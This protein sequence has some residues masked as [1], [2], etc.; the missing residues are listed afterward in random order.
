LA[1]PAPIAILS[2]NRPDYLRQVLASLAAQQGAALE[3]RRIILFQDGWHNAYS[4]RGAA[5]FED[6]E[7]CIAA[8]RDLIPGGEVMAASN[9]LGVAENYLRAE[10]HL[11]ETLGA[12]C[13]Y[14]FED[15]LVL[16]PRYLATLD[17][18]RA[19][20]EGMEEVGYFACYGNL[21]ASLADQLARPRQI[22]RL[23]HLW[24]FGLFRRHWQ[25]MQPLLADYYDLVLGRDYHPRARRTPE[26]LARYRAKGIPVAVSSQ[27]DVKKAITYHLGRVALN[28]NLVSARYIGETGLH[29]NPQ[30]YAANR[31]AETVIP[32]VPRVEFDL[33]DAADL[34]AMRERELDERRRRIAAKTAEIAARKAPPTA[35][36]APA[37]A[38]KLGKPRMDPEEI[39]LFER[40]LASGRRHY[41]EFGTGGST[42]LASRAGFETLVGVDSDAEWARKVRED[43]AIAPLV[44]AGRA[45]ILHADIGPVGNWGS[46]VDRSTAERWPRYLATMWAEWDRRG[47]FPDLVLVDGRFRVACCLSVALLA[48]AARQ[49]PL[50]LLHDVQDVRPAYRR[51]FDAFHLEEQAG[52]LC[53]LSPR[54][55]VSPAANLA[56]MLGRLFEVT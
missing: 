14:F 27:D 55:R 40:V 49:A 6:I 54:Q 19:A 34:A 9:N 47:L 35:P 52:T 51:V 42:L 50:V 7:A 20:T 31:Y 18:L 38:T 41:A 17:A 32:D 16:A 24:G 56:G 28:T 22:R 45:S 2:F 46:P 1:E 43:P 4:N 8:F 11:F 13:G 12:A 25:A 36:A 3:G 30:R 48:A 10:K 37:P 53:V 29:S 33:P 5:R 15:D 23:E 44:T 21:Q 26:I 39:A